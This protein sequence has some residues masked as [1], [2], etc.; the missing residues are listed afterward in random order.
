MSR[1]RWVAALAGVATAA[2]ALTGCTNTGAAS[3]ADVSVVATTNVY[4]SIVQRL[5]SGIPARRVAVTSILSDPSIDPH[6]YEATARDE[7]AV[8]RAELLIENG[9]GYDSFAA[10]LEQAAG[11]HPP[12]IDAV[13][14]SGHQHDTDLNEHVW[15]DLPTVARVVHRIARFFQTRYPQYAPVVDRNAARFIAALNRLEAA[16]ARIKA[17][18]AGAGV[19]VTEPVPLYLLQACGL[20]NRTPT[21]FSNAIEDGTD[22]SP[23]VLQDTLGLFTNHEVRL[24]VYNEQTAGPQTDQVIAAARHDGVPVIAVTETLPAGL[25]YLE[26]M[27]GILRQVEGALS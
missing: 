19:A 14:L 10:T 17:T 13:Q 4:G 27:A 7:L 24:L 12:T 25:T 2:A 8:S 5:L 20:V 9:G 26:W 21:E 1:R 11:H 23:R 6:E 15:Y 16:E 22:A 3:N 18:F